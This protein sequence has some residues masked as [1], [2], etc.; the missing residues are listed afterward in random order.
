MDESGSPIPDADVYL[1]R[2]NAFRTAWRT[3]THCFGRVR[4]I[5]RATFR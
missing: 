3:E 5:E 1:V 4:P 2:R